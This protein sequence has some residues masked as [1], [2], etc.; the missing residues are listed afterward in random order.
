MPYTNNMRSLGL[1]LA[2]AGTCL[3]QSNMCV[4]Y[5][6]HYGETYLVQNNLWGRDAGSGSQCSAVHSIGESGV[7]WSTTW[8]WSGGDDDPKSYSYS[9]LNFD[10][11]PVSAIG[12][13]QT[14]AH[15]TYSRQDLRANVA[16]DLFTAADVN[17]SNEGGDYELMVW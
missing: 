13:M 1:L 16:Y 6:G 10:K 12:S 3:A 5:E 11:K 14:S 8:Q 17:H 4:Q 7:A 15:W 9:G 2:V